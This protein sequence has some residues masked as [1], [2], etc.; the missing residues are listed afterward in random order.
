MLRPKSRTG[1][2][3]RPKGYIRFGWDGNTYKVKTVQINPRKKTCRLKLST[4]ELGK[5]WA[6]E[7]LGDHRIVDEI[8]HQT[9]KGD[10]DH[11]LLVLCK[12]AAQSGQTVVAPFTLLV[13]VEQFEKMVDDY[14]HA[15]ITK[16]IG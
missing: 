4:P 3:L 15:E 14:Q 2:V 6:V 10:R 11:V 1:A 12:T 7:F 13:P 5:D 9:E 8:M 16:Y